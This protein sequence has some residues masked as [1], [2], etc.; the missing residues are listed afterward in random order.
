MLDIIPPSLF[1]KHAEADFC[2]WLRALNIHQEDKK[3]LLIFWA[4]RVGL[5]LRADMFVQAGLKGG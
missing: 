3:Q 4:A 5:A 1:T 2:A